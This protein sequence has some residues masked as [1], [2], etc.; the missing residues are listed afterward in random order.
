M[1]RPLPAV[2]DAPVIEGPASRFAR[3]VGLA[4]LV[5]ATFLPY[6][7]CIAQPSEFEPPKAVTTTTDSYSR[8]N[9]ACVPA[10]RIEF[11][12]RRLLLGEP[13][14]GLQD[15]LLLGAYGTSN[16]YGYVLFF[17]LAPWLLLLWLALRRGGRERRAVG[18]LLWILSGAIPFFVGWALVS[19][20]A[21]GPRLDPWIGWPVATGAAV[22]LAWRPP[23]RRAPEDVEATLSTH[24]LIALGV[25]LCRPTLDFLDWAFDEGHS[26]ASIAL[27]MAHNYR[28]GFWLTLTALSLIAAPLYF[29]EESM[30]GLYDRCRPWRPRSSTP[31][32]TSTSTG[33]TETGTPS[34]T[35][36]APPDSSPS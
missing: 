5:L 3:R 6:H 10:A 7:G 21:G 35:A 30:R 26:L 22:F 14:E 28:P 32:P 23:G 27:A 4:L 33:S 18:R 1:A 25:A 19:G 24:A 17:G 12:I 31:T 34:S 15:R 13:R 2:A 8:D 29:S 20:E 36:P 9:E 11:E 16:D